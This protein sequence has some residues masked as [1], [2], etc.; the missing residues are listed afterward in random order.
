MANIKSAK[1]RI[2]VIETKTLRNKM[3]KSAL[4]TY[5]KKFEAAFEAKN[6][7]ESKTAFATVSKALDMAASKGIIH[8]NKA[9]RKKS[10]LALKLN[11]LNA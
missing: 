7:E 9:A 6:V 3:I 5:I 4:K 1:K 8:K 2:K 10:R 11:S